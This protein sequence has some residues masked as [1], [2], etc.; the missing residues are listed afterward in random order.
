RGERLEPGARPDER[1]AAGMLDL[2]LV[3]GALRLHGT[4][5]ES[6]DVGLAHARPDLV[7]HVLERQRGQLVRE[8][9]ALDLLVGLDRPRLD[10]QRRGVDAVRERVEPSGRVRRRLADHPVRGLRPLRELEADAL[11]AALS[12]DRLRELERARRRWTRVA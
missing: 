12:A 1:I 8:S 10:E 11:V 6:C 5:P 9:H 7:A 2:P 4:F 3:A